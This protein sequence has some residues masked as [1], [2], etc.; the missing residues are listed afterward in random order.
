M[1]EIIGKTASKL[2]FVAVIWATFVDGTKAQY[3]LKDSDVEMTTDGLIQ[4]CSYDFAI[5]DIIIPA[6]LMVKR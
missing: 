1:R 4:S 6:T 5:K 3:T 2:V